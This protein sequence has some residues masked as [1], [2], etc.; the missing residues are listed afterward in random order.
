MKKLL[1]PPKNKQKFIEKKIVWSP[2]KDLGVPKRIFKLF[3]EP[4]LLRD[5]HCTAFQL[6]VDFI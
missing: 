1:S 3:Q 5:Q 6:L 2:Q 4:D